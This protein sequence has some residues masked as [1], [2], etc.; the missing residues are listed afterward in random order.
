MMR[1]LVGCVLC[2]LAAIGSGAARAAGPSDAPGCVGTGVEDCLRSLRATM[3]LNESF[4]PGAMARRHQTD[5]NGRPLGGGMI[6]IYGR[7]PQR[8]DQFVILLHLRPDDTVERAESNLLGN[9][10]AA[11][12]ET[13]Y[14]A[15]GLYE[16]TGRLAGRRCS[17]AS[18]IEIYRFFE[19]VVK[20][21]IAR[22]RQDLST[23]LAGLHRVLGHAGP[24]PFVCGG[25]TFS[26][27]DRL[28]WRGNQDPEAAAKKTDFAYF[29]L[30]LP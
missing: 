20:P 16:M 19:N 28:E 24:L 9:L 21:R 22:T 4:L 27:N 8:W 15:S 29:E 11:R 17:A 18:R 5:V 26:Y 1:R 14:D 7:L 25:L 23:G 30:A 6:T 2:L 3:V 12:T 10:A 13:S